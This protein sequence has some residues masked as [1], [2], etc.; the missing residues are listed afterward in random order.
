MY[1]CSS[2][3]ISF[4]TLKWHLTTNFFQKEN[5]SYH[6]FHAS[7]SELYPPNSNSQLFK[8]GDTY[9]FDLFL[10][11]LI[12]LLGT[13]PRNS[14]GGPSRHLHVQSSALYLQIS[15][16]Y[17]SIHSTQTTFTCLEKRI[18]I[19]PSPHHQT[20]NTPKKETKKKNKKTHE[21]ETKIA[22]ER[23]NRPLLYKQYNYQLT[24]TE[25]NFMVILNPLWRLREPVCRPLK[26]ANGQRR[27]Y[28]CN[29]WQCRI[30]EHSQNK[31]VET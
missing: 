13:L 21:K 9:L 11:P 22:V 1:E 7:E 5:I 4:Q 12:G 29:K 6:L 23:L 19:N 17:C 15:I 27:Q 16:V 28:T 2:G 10:S 30:G 24:S 14:F 20:Q 3:N 26:K 18:N 25:D 8:N 31:P